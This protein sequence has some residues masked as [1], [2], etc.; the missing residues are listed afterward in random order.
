MPA[1]DAIAPSDKRVLQTLLWALKPFDNLTPRSIP[2]PYAI[3]FLT[4]ALD[5]G[6]PIGAYARDL[7][8]DRFVMTR[9]IQC[10]G[11][12]GRHGKPG[13]GLIT[14]KR[15]ETSPT[16]TEVYLTD[17]GRAVATQVLGSLYQLIE[18]LR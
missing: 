10:I 16:R 18:R 5:E 7:D 11:D 13:L 4:V 6:K 14:V 17:K 1:S 3:T 9:Y 15:T 8:F 12:K 2:L